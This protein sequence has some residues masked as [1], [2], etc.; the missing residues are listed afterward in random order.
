MKLYIPKE[1]LKQSS[2][3]LA[4]NSSGVMDRTHAT[5]DFVS[6]EGD[7]MGEEGMLNTSGNTPRQG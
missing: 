4:L 7:M 1:S 5:G 3:R 6:N 2:I